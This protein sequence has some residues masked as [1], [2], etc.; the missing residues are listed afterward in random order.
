MSH[1]RRIQS[2]FGFR[3]EVQRPFQSF[4]CFLHLQYWIWR[5][6]FLY[7]LSH[8]WGLWS[9]R[10]PVSHYLGYYYMPLLLVYYLF[11]SL[12]FKQAL[13]ILASSAV[14]LPFTVFSTD[15]LHTKSRA[16]QFHR[17]LYTSA[18]SWWFMEYLK[19]WM[20]PRMQFLVI[21]SQLNAGSNMF[22]AFPKFMS[23]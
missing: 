12:S 23:S 14:A 11:L 19:V 18:H 3:T 4:K 1:Y 13:P 9:Q 5:D 21:V 8:L 17:R 20:I 22:S 7:Q 2:F 16:L 6:L 10:F 15:P